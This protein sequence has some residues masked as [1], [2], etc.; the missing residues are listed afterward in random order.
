[1]KVLYSRRFWNKQIHFCSKKMFF[2]LIC[3]FLKSAICLVSRL[4]QICVPG[5]YVLGMLN[6]YLFTFQFY[7]TGEIISI[8]SVLTVIPPVIRAPRIAVLRLCLDVNGSGAQVKSLHEFYPHWSIDL[9]VRRKLNLIFLRRPKWFGS[10][11]LEVIELLIP[12]PHITGIPCFGFIFSEFYSHV[13]AALSHECLASDL[14]L[15]PS[16]VL[17][18]GNFSACMAQS[19]CVVAETMKLLVP[20]SKNVRWSQ[21]PGTETDSYTQPD[22]WFILIW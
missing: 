8:A 12:H 14:L 6:M 1:M 9:Q 7:L 17:A 16:I 2:C 10:L 22:H 21:A 4:R 20:S 15:V 5:K 19:S 3:F 11:T 13:R 18:S